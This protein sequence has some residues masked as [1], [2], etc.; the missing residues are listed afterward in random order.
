[1]SPN[2]VNIFL[3]SSVNFVAHDI[4]KYLAKDPRKLKLL[5]I[6]T[7]AEVEKGDLQW[8]KDDH[9]S[10]IKT[11]FKVTDFTITG[12]KLNEIRSKLEETDIIYVSGGNQFYLLYHIQQ[13]RC[14]KLISNL[15]KKGKI[16]IGTSAGSIVAGP[17]I[18]ITR[19]IDDAK[20][21]KYLNLKS[22]QGLGLVNFIVLPHWG[23]EY[24]KQ[25]YLTRRLNA[26]NQKYKI[27]LL[28]DYQYILVKDNW[29]QIVSVK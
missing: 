29:Y 16:Y 11:G 1:M 23:S 22:Y 6:D 15:V 26:Y 4:P 3:T 17:D 18:Y 7:A 20:K 12:K 14:A 5:F 8:L 10:L 24:F 19:F 21:A 13:T 28:N 9:N 2:D 25:I 27:I